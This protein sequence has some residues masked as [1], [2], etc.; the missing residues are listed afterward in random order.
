MILKHVGNQCS[1][2]NSDS[3]VD[4]GVLETGSTALRDLLCCRGSSCSGILGSS[5][6]GRGGRG[7]RGDSSGRCSRRNGR[8]SR[9]FEIR[10]VSPASTNTNRAQLD[11]RV[12]DGQSLDS[13]ANSDVVQIMHQR[14]T[15]LSQGSG[16][17]GP[18]SNICQKTSLSLATSSDSPILRINR[19]HGRSI[20]KLADN[21]T[22]T[23]INVTARLDT[24]KAC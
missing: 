1:E 17:V 7:G 22:D 11:V 19:P 8:S 24:R 20:A 9:G 6:C 3:C 15:T 21:V 12:Q 23:V 18:L 4:N 14:V 16:G 5:I 2:S 13:S 10:S